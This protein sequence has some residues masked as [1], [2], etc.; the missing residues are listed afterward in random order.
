MTQLGLGF[1]SD[2]FVRRRRKRGVRAGWTQPA[3][4]RSARPTLP[5]GFVKQISA[6]D[7]SETWMVCGGTCHYL[8]LWH[9]GS[10]TLPARR[11]ILPPQERDGERERERMRER[12]RDREG[13]ANRL[14]A[15]ANL[16]QSPQKNNPQ[17]PP[18]THTR[19]LNK[20]VL[21]MGPPSSP[22]QY[23]IHPTPPQPHPHRGLRG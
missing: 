17:Y 22:S 19:N 5:P 11:A 18:N 1:F 16:S 9:L 3:A 23:R 4:S 14:T 15:G 8:T 6:V 20:K 13:A 7:P 10:G 12:D 2:L 21:V